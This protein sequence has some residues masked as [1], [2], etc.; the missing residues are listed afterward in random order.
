MVLEVIGF[1]ITFIAVAVGAWFLGNF[2]VTVFTGGRTFLH[3][4]LRPIEVG[5]YRLSGIKED[6][7]Q[8]W[9]GYLAAMLAVTVVS[10]LVTY[11]ILRV[12]NHLPL[13]PQGFAGVAP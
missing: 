9:V 11:V 6:Q 10:L 4:V 8:S 7:E 13:N 2:M 12:Q 3:P 1:A 5:F